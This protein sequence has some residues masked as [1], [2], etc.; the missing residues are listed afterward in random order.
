M[1]C[2]QMDKDARLNQESCYTIEY[3]I[4]VAN[5]RLEHKDTSHIEKYIDF[6][7]DS[8]IKHFNIDHFYQSGFL[9]T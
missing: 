7:F 9:Y 1:R 3:A 8:M 2:L 5:L 4:T 6:R